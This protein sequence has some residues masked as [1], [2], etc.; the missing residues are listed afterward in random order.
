MSTMQ[1]E[2]PLLCRIDAPSVLHPD[3]IAAIGSYREAVQVCWAL[4]HDKAA[5]A[6]SACARHIGAQ[7]SHMSSYLS[8]EPDQRDMPAKFIKAFQAWCGNSAISQYLAREA[9][10]SV[11]EEVQA[12]LQRKSA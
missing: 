6:H 2:L 5:G 3:R 10:L 7:V 8:D 11:T 4:R 9:Q 1:L 12:L